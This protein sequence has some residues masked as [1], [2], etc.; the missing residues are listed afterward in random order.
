MSRRARRRVQSVIKRPSELRKLDQPVIVF[1]YLQDSGNWRTWRFRLVSL[2]KVLEM[3]SEGQAETLTRKTANGLVI[4][5]RETQASRL[6]APSPTTL[7]L[8]T[9][10]A[11]GRSGNPQDRLEPSD[12]A[13]VV[14]FRVWPLIGD[15]K[16]VA[17]RP[18]ISDSERILAEKLFD[19]ARGVKE[20]KQRTRASRTGDVQALYF[21]A[22]QVA[23]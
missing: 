16:A 4:F 5:Y 17:V 3:V 13:H 15:T 23:A 1:S 12:Y 9:M 2:R 6:S 10:N 22:P 20:S 19:R 14:K 7:T 11:V 18:R 21:D 8:A